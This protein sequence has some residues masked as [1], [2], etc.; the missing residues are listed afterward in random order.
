MFNFNFSNGMTDEE[1]LRR[2]FQQSNAGMS[3]EQRLARNFQRTIAGMSDEQR[4]ARNFQQSIAGRSD[5]Q[6]LTRNFQQTIAGMS[7]EQRLARN[8]HQSAQNITEEQRTY[9]NN[10]RRQQTHFKKVSH[11]WNYE[12][13]C[14]HCSCIHLESASASQRKLCCRN[15]DFLTNIKYPKLFELPIFLK[16]LMLDRTEHLSSRSSFYNNIFSIAV[17]GYENGR[18]GVG[19][20]QINGPSSLKINGRSFHFFPSSSKQKFG[21]IA[22]FT[23]DGAFQAER[24]ANTLNVNQQDE[25]VNRTFVKG[26]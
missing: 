3:D 25:R 23:Y 16:R 14:V 7:D 1:R 15:G 10:Y 24:H 11:S 22:N 17:T 21:G 18:D 5:E 9:R 12:S 26:M 8:Y 4:L 6:R 19:C 13:P 2:N 20:E